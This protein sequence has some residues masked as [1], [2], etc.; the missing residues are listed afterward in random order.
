M[1]IKPATVSFDLG[2]GQFCERTQLPL[3][4]AFSCTIHKAQGL[5]LHKAVVDC[6][7][8]ISRDGMAYT[9]LSLVR[10]INDVILLNFDPTKFRPP[11]HVEEEFAR[12]RS[13]EQQATTAAARGGREI[14]GE[15]ETEETTATTEQPQGQPE[16]EHETDPP[17][18]T[19]G[20]F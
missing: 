8:S 4:I 11:E 19:G 15:V 14:P 20:L 12:L 13:A 6:G 10:S 16:E 9:A 1:R 7:E 17:E 3:I 5:T 2:A 18:E